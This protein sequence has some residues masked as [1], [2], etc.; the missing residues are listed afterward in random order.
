MT[1]ETNK[2]VRLASRPVGWVSEENFTITEEPAADPADGEV[3][4]RNLFMSVDPYMRGR[5]NDVKSYIPPFQIGEVLQAG[6]VGQVVAS[7]FDGIAE[8]DHVMGMLG[9]ENFSVSDGRLL[10][11]IPQGPVPLSY[12]L[13]VLGMPGMTAYIGLMKIAEAKEGDNVFVT[14][15]SG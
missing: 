4:V 5:M 3:L 8:G 10:R 1:Q 6:T 2:Q 13:G 12:H 15:A 11:K 9:W 7:N 14:A